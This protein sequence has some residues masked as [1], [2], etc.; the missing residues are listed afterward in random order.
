MKRTPMDK[1]GIERV[2][3][4]MEFGG[5]VR[6]NCTINTNPAL[7]REDMT[8]MRQLLE[9]LLKRFNALEELLI[10]NK[11]IDWKDYLR[12]EEESIDNDSKLYKSK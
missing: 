11:I 9:I 1:L 8:S 10:D 6:D 12:R 7:M 2:D 5:M 3:I 4:E